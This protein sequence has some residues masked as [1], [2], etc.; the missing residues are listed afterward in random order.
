[1]VYPAG[2]KA[3][4][5]RYALSLVLERD[6]LAEYL[7]LHPLVENLMTELGMELRCAAGSRHSAALFPGEGAS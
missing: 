7:P 3:V 5:T 4:L 6:M 2:D 1:M